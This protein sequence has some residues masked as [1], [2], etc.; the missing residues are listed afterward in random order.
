MPGK[1][2]RADRKPDSIYRDLGA[3]ER[4]IVDRVRGKPLRS[5]FI[6]VIGL[7]MRLQFSGWLQY[8]FPLPFAFGLFLIAGFFALIGTPIVALSML[9]LAGALLL[10]AATDI[11]TVKFRIRLPE[12][13]PPRR[14]SLDL[15]DLMRSRRSCRSFQTRDLC[16]EDVD[17][18]M[19][20]LQRH[21]AEEKLGD[22]VVR[23]E[24][25]KA[26][27]TVWPTVNAREFIV[28]IAPREYDRRAVMDVGRTLQKV[29]MDAT[30]MG[31]GTCWIGPGADHRS[32]ISELGDR[33]D[34][35]RDNIIC[36]VAVGYASRHI[37]LFIRLFNAQFNR[38]LPLQQLFFEDP[39]MEHP[40]ALEKPPY[41]RFGRVFEICQWA[42]SS[43]NGQTTRCVSPR[44][45]D[46]RKPTSPLRFD[47]YAATAS[48]YYAA[49]ALGIWCANWDLG[50]R[51]L[52]IKGHWEFLHGIGEPTIVPH[53]DI[54]WVEA[55]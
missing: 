7:K 37:P 33:I 21:S 29:V 43:Y 14:D 55:D 13:R 36:V 6:R 5:I 48:R 35:S 54:S 23:F 2:G 3:N 39:E 42:P 46:S 18:L 11:V 16:R 44:D 8:I 49:V 9:G 31:V 30:R 19:G 47:F 15:F 45:R 26:P 53:Y 41:D 38:R 50:C 24:Y 25:I 40:L 51:E 34:E 4:A 17:E 1:K 22:A 28:A 27:L 32:I 10:I 52:E 12:R 20:S